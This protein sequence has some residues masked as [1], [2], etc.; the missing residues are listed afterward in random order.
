MATMTQTAFGPSP[1]FPYL[2]SSE[3]YQKES[4]HYQEQDNGIKS[5]PYGFP[6][7]VSSSMAWKSPAIKQENSSWTYT[8]TEDQLKSI[9]TAMKTFEGDYGCTSSFYRTTF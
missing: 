3:I 5:L 1:D 2:P 7:F 8:L 9:D 4:A 6:K